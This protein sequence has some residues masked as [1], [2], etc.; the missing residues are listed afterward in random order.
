MFRAMRRDRHLRKMVMTVVVMMMVMMMVC[1]CV[2]VSYHAIVMQAGQAERNR[3]GPLHG[4]N[5]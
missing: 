5:R 3:W 2:C 4:G 1:E